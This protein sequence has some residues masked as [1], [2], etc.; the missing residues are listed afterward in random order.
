MNKIYSKIWN[1][2]LSQV[3]VASELAN[4]CSNGTTARQ[5]ARR[6]ISQ[7]LGTFVVGASA[8]IGGLA[9]TTSAQAQVSCAN[10]PYNVY[11]GSATCAGLSSAADAGGATAIGFA[12]H[13]AALNA[14][15]I[16][17]QA[18]A[19]GINSIY[20]GART[21]AGTGAL[22]ESSIAI[23]T[24][25]TSSGGAAV[26]IGVQSFASGVSGLA[27][28]TQVHNA[29]ANTVAMGATASADANSA[30]SVVIGSSSKAV[31]AERRRAWHI[32]TGEQRASHRIGWLYDCKR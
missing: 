29:G 31:V 20:M 6:A 32:G 30:N 8:M 18:N 3:V 22:A 27:I 17:F 7:Q 11:S 14:T 13:S 9:W 10:P 5:P 16:G 15:S 1:R 4:G 28:G 26:G 21:A 12:A 25:V 24:D 2:A 23:G 19:L